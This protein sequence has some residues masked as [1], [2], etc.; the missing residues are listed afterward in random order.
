MTTMNLLRRAVLGACMLAGA[1]AMAHE[2]ALRIRPDHV[3]LQDVVRHGAQL[4]A[5]GER[6][7][8]MTSADDGR[9]WQAGFAPVTRTLSALAFADERRGVVVGH[10]GT[11]LVTDD[12]GGHW[13]AISV[14]AVGRDA[15]L[16]VTHL[17]GG[18]FVAYGAFGLY[19]ESRDYGMSW[20]RKQPLGA[21]FDRHIS[22]VAQVGSQ[23]LMVGESGTLAR[24]TDGGQSWR[25]L[26]SP[27]QGSLFG[28]LAAADGALL[29]Y[30]MR[31]QVFRSGDGG[32]SWRK[33]E[34]GTSLALMNGRRLD[35]GRLILVGNAGLLAVSGDNG[36]S[37]ALQTAPGGKGI[38]QV[39]TG[40]SGQL[41]A[42]GEGGVES[43]RLAG[44]TR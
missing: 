9:T 34:L 38:A 8:V 3:I 25:K 36:N 30:G 28:A 31:G 23:L 2:A 22:Q 21:D 40:G 42:V 27:Y 24:S 15:L 39:A 41:L 26:D 19:I 14:E 20:T 17:G 37:F 32:D 4:V 16:G 44:A 33:V 43:L 12:S 11:V 35:D 18:T 29:I 10:G 7:L 5:V 1:P 6:G 13:R